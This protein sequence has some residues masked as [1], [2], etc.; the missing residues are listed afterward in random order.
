MPKH[1]GGRPTKYRP[2]MPESLIKFFKRPLYVNEKVKSIVDGKTIITYKKVPNKS[3][4]LIHWCLEQK[5][6]PW[7]ISAWANDGKHPEFSKALIVAKQL[8]ETFF[9]ELG[10]K[11]D[12]NPFMTFQTLKNVSGWRDKTEVESKHTEEINHTLS[13]KYEM[14]SDND[15][16]NHL[17]GRSNGRSQNINRAGEN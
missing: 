5:I 10:I 12:H 1:A 16:I 13:V 4:Y 8:Q 15:L 14:L 7:D 6:H 9:N 3:P 17:L 11:G 2:T